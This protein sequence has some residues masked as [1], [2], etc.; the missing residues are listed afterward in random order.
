MTIRAQMERTKL[1]RL[2]EAL[3]ERVAALEARIEVLEQKRGPGRPKKVNDEA[4]HA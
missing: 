2:I 3:S 1:K 4:I